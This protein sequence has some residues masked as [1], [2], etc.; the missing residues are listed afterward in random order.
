MSSKVISKRLGVESSLI[1]ARKKLSGVVYTIMAECPL[2]AFCAE[3]GGVRLYLS[4]LPW[5]Y[6]IPHMAMYS[7]GELL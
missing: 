3:A 7:S 6:G 5:L 4:S 2:L 1:N